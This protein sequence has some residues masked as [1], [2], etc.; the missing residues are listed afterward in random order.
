MPQYI[1]GKSYGSKSSCGS[2][3]LTSS[4]SS[5]VT[6]NACKETV[7]FFGK[8]ATKLLEMSEAIDKRIQK[9]KSES[10]P[11]PQR[12]VIMAEIDAPVMTIGVKYEYVEYI[13]RHGPP[14]NG[15]FDEA[16]LNV[17][18][19]ELGMNTNPSLQL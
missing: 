12:G 16:K 9:I 2:K 1:V 5:S 10:C 18:R 14:V 13:R 7:R 3:T 6:G 8:L 15:I 17:I 19:I 11:K 4:S